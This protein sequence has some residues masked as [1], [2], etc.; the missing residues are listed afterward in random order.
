MYDSNRK[1]KFGGKKDFS[2]PRSG[3]FKS[4]GDREG[5]RSSGPVTLHDATCAECGNACK[6]PFKP[7]GKKP[8][9][10]GDC[11]RQSEGGGDRDRKPAYGGRPQAS[12]SHAGLEE[13]NRKLDRILRILEEGN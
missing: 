11:F 12:Q 5:G 2:K 1:S 8:V 10:C 13:L 6:V 7:N 4:F 9:F 3:G